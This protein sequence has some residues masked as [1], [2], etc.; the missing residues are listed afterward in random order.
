MTI[1]EGRVKNRKTL[2]IKSE[3]LE[4]RSKLISNDKES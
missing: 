1:E 2:R 3:K 4:D